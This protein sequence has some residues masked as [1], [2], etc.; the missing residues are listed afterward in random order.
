MRKM[1]QTKANWSRTLVTGLTYPTTSGHRH[2]KKLR[3]DCLDFILMKF[4]CKN[5][6]ICYILIYYP[7]NFREWHH[8]YVYFITIIFAI[9]FLLTFYSVIKKQEIYFKYLK[10][11]DFVPCFWLKTFSS[12]TILQVR[13]P[14]N[15]KFPLKGKD[16]DVV[17]EKKVSFFHFIIVS[18]NLIFLGCVEYCIS[19]TYKGFTMIP[20]FVFAIRY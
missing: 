13:I 18:L 10:E 5:L 17:I 1:K 9:N 2:W 14:L 7:I 15:V 16:M 4:Y 8:K 12:Y 3:L 20:T 11:N 19:E 6:Y